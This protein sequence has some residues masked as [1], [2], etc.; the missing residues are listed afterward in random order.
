LTKLKIVVISKKFKKKFRKKTKKIQ[1][2][3]TAF[4]F[5]FLGAVLATSIDGYTQRTEEFN[6]NLESIS[7]SYSV[8]FNDELERIFHCPDILRKANADSSTRA[9]NIKL[10]CSNYI[11]GDKLG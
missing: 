1:K 4:Q 3:M 11:N 9:E 8:L 2:Q 10:G 5:L 7:S 6:A